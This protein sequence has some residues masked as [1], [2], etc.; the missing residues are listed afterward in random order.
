M[1][2]TG[3][4]LSALLKQVARCTMS[5]LLCSLR[6]K[7]NVPFFCMFVCFCGFIYVYGSLWSPV[8]NFDLLMNLLNIHLCFKDIRMF[9]ETH[10]LSAAATR[11]QICVV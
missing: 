3:T 8:Y 10:K 2:E 1:V 7:E 6:L 4:Q 5:L 11:I 9:R